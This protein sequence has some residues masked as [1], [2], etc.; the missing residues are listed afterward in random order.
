MGNNWS[1]TTRSTAGTNRYMGAHGGKTRRR[2]A[3]TVGGEY[4]APYQQQ[5]RLER[6]YFLITIRNLVQ[7]ESTTCEDIQ[8]VMDMN[9]KT[10]EKREYED[11][12]AGRGPIPVQTDFADRMKKYIGPTSSYPKVPLEE[13][14][15]EAL[16]FGTTYAPLFK[17]E[18][19]TYT[20]FKSIKDAIEKKPEGVSPASYRAFL[21]ASELDGKILNTLFCTD[22]WAEKRTTDTVAYSLLNALYVDRP[23]GTMESSTAAECAAMVSNFIGAKALAPYVKSGATTSSFDNAAFREVPRQLKEFCGKISTSGKRGTSSAESQRVLMSA[24]KML[25]DMYDEHLK[26][27]VDLIRK[28]LSAK[29][30]GYR[31]PPYL[32]LDNRFRDSERGAIAAMEELIAEARKLLSEHYLA[33]EKVYNGALAALVRQTLGNYVA[34]KAGV[35]ALNKAAEEL[36]KF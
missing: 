12:Y 15:E 3:R 30:T 29:T 14:K 4:V 34:P 33:V 13:P 6:Q 23:E 9:G 24:H 10:Y 11:H 2:R 35:N 31:Q 27:C 17:R 16:R 18:S 1:T 26:A 21:L 22:G 20:K 32:E 7:C 8:F 19:D 28:A 36:D 5:P 25:R